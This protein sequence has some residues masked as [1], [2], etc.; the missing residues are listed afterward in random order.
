MNLV[1]KFNASPMAKV[2]LLEKMGKANFLT[3]L[4]KKGYWQI[5][6]S[7]TDKEKTAFTSPRGLFQFTHISF[8]LHGAVATFHR[9]MD[10]VL[11]PVKEY[12]ATYIDNIVVFISTW[13]EHIAHLRS[14]LK[15][16]KK[17]LLTIN[18]PKCKVA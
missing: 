9:L 3:P 8:G 11:A 10:T 6:L 13:E 4:D 2:D 12:A 7:E 17:M 15:E 5:L 16:L 18:P 14:V 1:S